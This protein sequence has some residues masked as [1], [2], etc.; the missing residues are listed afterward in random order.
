MSS[1]YNHVRSKRG[2]DE[3][4]KA[5]FIREE[6]EHQERLEATGY[7][8]PPWRVLRSLQSLFSATQLQGESAVLL[9]GW[10]G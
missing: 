8:S 3:H 7:R 9:V 2:E 5:M 4:R 1:A 10:P 6:L